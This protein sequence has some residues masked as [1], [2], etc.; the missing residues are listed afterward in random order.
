MIYINTFTQNFNNI[1]VVCWRTHFRGL[2][3]MWRYGDA[4][5]C[6]DVCVCV[7]VYVWLSL[8]ASV[9]SAAV[10]S[11]LS[12]S[13]LCVYVCICVTRW[14]TH[15]FECSRFKLNICKNLLSPQFLHVFPRYLFNASVSLNTLESQQSSFTP[16]ATCFH[17]FA[18]QH[19][20]ICTSRHTHTHTHFINAPQ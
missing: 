8:Q 6:V 17:R 20:Y 7:C 19:K 13:F 16:S 9:V 18:Q 2:Q 15:V 10:R 11:D 12:L 4:R 3:N 5:I 14:G 1:L